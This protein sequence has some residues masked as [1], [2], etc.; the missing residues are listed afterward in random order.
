MEKPYGVHIDRDPALMIER[1]AELGRESSLAYSALQYQQDMAKIILAEISLEIWAEAV[2]ARGK[3]HSLSVIESMSYAHPRWRDY[4]EQLREIRD[5]SHQLQ[6]EFKAEE[7][8]LELL[9]SLESS[10]RSQL[11]AL[12]A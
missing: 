12:G 10:V 3:R 5:K 6:K 1:Y 9:R 8:R 2:D 4:I 11:K 7:L